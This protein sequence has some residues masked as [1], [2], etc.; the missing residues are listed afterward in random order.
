MG[1]YKDMIDFVI[2]NMEEMAGVDE[3]RSIQR[4]EAAN[5]FWQK[6]TSVEDYDDEE[7]DNG[8]QEIICIDS[9]WGISYN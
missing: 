6:Y 3:F 5:K 1:L 7:H 4:T 2:E 9:N 8:E